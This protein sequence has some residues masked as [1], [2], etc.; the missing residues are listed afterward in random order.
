MADAAYAMKER[1]CPLARVFGLTVR[2]VNALA[3]WPGL[4]F[5][6][7]RRARIAGSVE[8]RAPP[9]WDGRATWPWIMRNKVKTVLG[10]CSSDDAPSPPRFSRNNFRESIS[11]HVAYRRERKS[12]N[13]SPNSL[14]AL[15]SATL[16]LSDGRIAAFRAGIINSAA[17]EKHIPRLGPRNLAFGV[18]R[19]IPQGR[20]RTSRRDPREIN[21]RDNYRDRW[22]VRNQQLNSLRANE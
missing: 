9:A 3:G 4:L 14:V 16:M 10:A 5:P 15:V 11:P 22:Q 19:R 21:D 7:P 17:N 12:R 20:L 13:E 1:F 8:D 6:W 18:G 2:G